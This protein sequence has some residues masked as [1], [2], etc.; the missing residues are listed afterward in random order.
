M[1]SRPTKKRFP[2]IERFLLILITQFLLGLSGPVFVWR[3]TSLLFKAGNIIIGRR[4]ACILRDVIDLLIRIQEQTDRTADPVLHKIVVKKNAGLF[5]EQIPEVSC[6]N[7][8]LD[9]EQ[10]D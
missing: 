10:F 8:V 7:L 5:L 1:E 9:A 6:A 3:E 2:D 4:K